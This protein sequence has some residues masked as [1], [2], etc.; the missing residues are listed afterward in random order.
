MYYV[1]EHLEYYNNTHRRTTGKKWS[2]YFPII[3]KVVSEII[4]GFVVFFLFLKYSYNTNNNNII[5]DYLD[6]YFTYTR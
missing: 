3:R 1:F 4:I 5:S 2:F 6:V